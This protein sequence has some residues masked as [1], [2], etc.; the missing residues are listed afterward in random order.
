VKGTLLEPYL[1]MDGYGV[2]MKEDGSVYIHLHPVGSYSM[3]SQQ[4][5]LNR[6]EN[7]IGP[8]KF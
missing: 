5:M 2:V 8:R 7:E 6:F 4:T 1:G 3:A